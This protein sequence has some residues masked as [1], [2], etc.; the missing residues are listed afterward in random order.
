MCVQWK[1]PSRIQMCHADKQ[2]DMFVRH[3]VSVFPGSWMNPKHH[4]QHHQM[5]QLRVHAV[6]RHGSADTADS[7]VHQPARR[8]KLVM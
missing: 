3:S 7:A 8:M 4:Q 1:L 5:L 2:I 6:T